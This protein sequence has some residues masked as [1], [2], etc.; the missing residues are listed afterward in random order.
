MV[1]HKHGGHVPYTRVCAFNPSFGIGWQY[2][3]S[4]YPIE[5]ARC[6]SISMTIVQQGP[7]VTR[8]AQGLDCCWDLSGIPHHIMES[9]GDGSSCVMDL[10]VGHTHTFKPPLESHTTL[11]IGCIDRGANKLCEMFWHVGCVWDHRIINI[12]WQDLVGGGSIDKPP[13]RALYGDSALS[14]MYW[15]RELL[16]IDTLVLFP[17]ACEELG[18]SCLLG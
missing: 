2:V 9:I 1:Q 3:S 6:P 17:L 12:L 15:T 5:W 8:G 16:R 10:V 11:V 18:H 4:W 13:D 7:W 14:L